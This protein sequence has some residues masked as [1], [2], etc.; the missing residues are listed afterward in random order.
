[1]KRILLRSFSG[2]M[3]VCMFVLTISGFTAKQEAHTEIVVCDSV[4]CEKAKIIIDT[5]NGEE[6]VSPRSILCIFGHNLA[7]GTAIETTHRYW[8]TAPRC[9]RIT[10][11]VRYCTRSSCNYITYTM[12]ADDRIRCCN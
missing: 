6:T 8:A 9:R 4:D 12:I 10:Y 11:D 7:R 1:M 2:F 5:I 3:V